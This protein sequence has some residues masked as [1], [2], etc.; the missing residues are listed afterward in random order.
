MFFYPRKLKT[1]F[2]WSINN[3]MSHWKH[4]NF[5]Y[6]SRCYTLMQRKQKYRSKKNSTEW[7]KWNIDIS[8][9]QFPQL[10]WKVW[11]FKKRQNIGIFN[12]NLLSYSPRHHGWSFAGEQIV[13]KSFSWLLLV[14]VEEDSHEWKHH[15]NS[16]LH[17]FAFVPEFRI[18]NEH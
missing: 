17:L 4:Q 10:I 7:I 11:E 2:H 14:F 16:H 13:E 12:K 5:T 3:N 1:Q 15:L 8:D 18:L 6:W 9:L